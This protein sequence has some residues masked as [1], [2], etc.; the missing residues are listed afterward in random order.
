MALGRSRRGN[1]FPTRSRRSFRFSASW[2]TLPYITKK[3]ERCRAAEYITRVRLPESG[4]TFLYYY[5]FP[6]SLIAE[7]ASDADV[8]NKLSV[9]QL[10]GDGA[11]LGY[12]HGDAL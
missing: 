6:F 5:T 8:N 10:V 3:I 11:D 1:S 4:A 7:F 9:D 12:S 2:P